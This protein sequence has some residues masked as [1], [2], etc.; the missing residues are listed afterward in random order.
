MSTIPFVDRRGTRSVRWSKDTGD[1]LQLWIADMDLACAPPIVAALRK[2]IEEP[3]FG[4][5]TPCEAASEALC[6]YAATQGM[7]VHPDWIV[8][9]PGV[10]PSLQVAAATVARLR[11]GSIAC[12][13]PIYGPFRRACDTYGSGVQRIGLERVQDRLVPDFDQDFS[14]TAGLFLCNPHNPGGA[15]LER[16][17]LTDLAE[18]LRDTDCIVVSDE[19]HSPLLIDPQAV[20]TTWLQVED[21][22]PS[23][24]LISPSKLANIAG[25]A[26]SAAIIPDPFV[27]GVFDDLREGRTGQVNALA[28][29][30]I[31]ASMTEIDDWVAE[32]L[33][34]L[35][36]QYRLIDQ[37]AQQWDQV[38]LP[39]HQATFLAWMH[40]DH[41]HPHQFFLEQGVNLSPGAEFG[42]PGWVRL[43]YATSREMLEKALERMS[44]ALS[45]LNR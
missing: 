43:N 29:D 5:D 18:K 36:A 35:R 39:R 33:E 37:W 45:T 21:Q 10:V 16:S 3:V 14:N 38:W 9:M 13:S 22:K 15:V 32:L 26:A 44:K 28:W 23:I 20:H 31:I 42:G 27:R 12:P 30:P 2:R 11:S 24:T 25:I 4:Y 19:I 1:V 8:W 40:V 17:E 34:H 7:Q 41:P 6:H